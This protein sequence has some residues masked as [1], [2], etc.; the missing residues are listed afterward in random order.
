MN[1]VTNLPQGPEGGSLDVI[2]DPGS[3]NLAVEQFSEIVEQLLPEEIPQAV[4]DAKMNRIRELV[5]GYCAEG[6]D[7]TLPT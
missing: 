7:E 4:A 2:T 1:T 6:G 3:E 5:S